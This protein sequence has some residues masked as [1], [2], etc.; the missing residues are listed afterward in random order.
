MTVAKCRLCIL[1]F[2]ADYSCCSYNYVSSAVVVVRE[3]LLVISVSCFKLLVCFTETS[4]MA[5]KEKIA[6][7]IFDSMNEAA[8][9]ESASI[10]G[11]VACV[12]PMKT[13][14]GAAYFEAK[15]TDGTAQM[16]VVGFQ[17]S[18]RKRL[19]TFEEKGV[20]V[21][22]KLPDKASSVW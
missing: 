22:S 19:V 14:K 20:S 13:G 12:S 10:E 7:R 15:L 6:P 5:Q 16:R 4:E 3:V 1:P 21:S 18:Q 2:R 11:V 9:T 8:E 17:G